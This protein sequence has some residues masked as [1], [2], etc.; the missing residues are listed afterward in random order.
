VRP[1][2]AC[3]DERPRDGHFEKVSSMQ[4]LGKRVNWIEHEE[5][6]RKY[7]LSEDG[8][9]KI[10]NEG[11]PGGSWY[12]LWAEMEWQGPGGKYEA[13]TRLVRMGTLE[14]CKGFE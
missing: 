10:T 9:F 5:H 4:V 1:D 6:K 11:K 13:F 12:C 8:K 14:E 3:V 2:E 7:L